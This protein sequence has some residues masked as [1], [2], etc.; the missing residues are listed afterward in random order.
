MV[1]VSQRR[2]L[3]HL[4][5][6]LVSNRLSVQTRRNQISWGGP[7]ETSLYLHQATYSYIPEESTFCAIIMKTRGLFTEPLVDVVYVS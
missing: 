5:S 2:T 4:V 6:K 1:L 3:Q 7:Y